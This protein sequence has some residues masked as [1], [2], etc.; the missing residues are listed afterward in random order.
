M[1]FDPVDGGP[2]VSARL[3]EPRAFLWI[4]LAMKQGHGTNI[5]YKLLRK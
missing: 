1:G 2:L 3:L 5:A 4:Y